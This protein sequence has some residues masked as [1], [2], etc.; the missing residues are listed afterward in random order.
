MSFAGN[1]GSKRYTESAVRKRLL[2]ALR[3]RKFL[4]T[5]ALIPV[6]KLA[7]KTHLSIE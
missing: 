5:S 6:Q 1:Y 4:R 3:A 2:Q 7:F